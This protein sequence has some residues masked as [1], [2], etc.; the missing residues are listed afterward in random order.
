MGEDIT[1]QVDDNLNVNLLVPGGFKS[2]KPFKLMTHGFSSSV[3]GGKT[4]F[5]NAW[6]QAYAQEVN[7]ILVN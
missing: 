7:V 3:T 6:M 5:V 2:N 1:C 4:A